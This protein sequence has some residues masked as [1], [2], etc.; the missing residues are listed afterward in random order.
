MFL[1]HVATLDQDS[2]AYQVYHTQKRLMLPGLVEE[3]S[4]MLAELQVCDITQYSPGQWETLVSKK[5]MDKNTNDLLEN[6]KRNYKKI[7]HNVMK[8]DKLEIKSYMKNLHLSEA[9]DRFRLRSFMTKT[10]K[11]NFSSDKKYMAELW[12]CWHCPQV[13]SQTHI[14]V[15]P[16]YQKLNRT[17][18]WTMTMIYYL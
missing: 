5:M 10:V 3:C 12:T 2:I 13:D 9:R 18:T 7:D 4:E 16:A 14:K 8:E 17:R 1:H 6:M 11:T 15:C